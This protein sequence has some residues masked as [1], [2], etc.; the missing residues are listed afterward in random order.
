LEDKKMQKKIIQKIINYKKIPNNILNYYKNIDKWNNLDI[1]QFITYEDIINTIYEYLLIKYNTFSILNYDIDNLYNNNWN[2][3][4]EEGLS[5][6]VFS[7]LILIGLHN[8]KNNVDKLILLYKPLQIYP[9]KKSFFE[10][11]F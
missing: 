6:Y 2:S 9:Y 5:E 3:L 10:K 1:S 7:K 8:I 4:N 11:I